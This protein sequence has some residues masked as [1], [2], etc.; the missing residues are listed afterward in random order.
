MRKRENETSS[1][2]L[3][4]LVSYQN[5]GKGIEISH[6]TPPTHVYLPPLSTFAH[7]GDIFA[8]IDELTHHNHSKS[9][10]YYD[11]IMV[12]S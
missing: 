12:Q 10:V 11:I 5:G 8:K 3:A 1:F 2:F 6:I 4:V 9:I 7:Q